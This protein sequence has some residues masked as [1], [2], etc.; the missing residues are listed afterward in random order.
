MSANASPWVAR[1]NASVST[2]VVCNI[3]RLG[4]TPERAFS[5]YSGRAQLE[6][7]LGAAPPPFILPAATE[8]RAR[9]PSLGP[10]AFCAVRSS[11]SSMKSA[12][13]NR[14]LCRGMSK[15]WR[16]SPISTLSCALSEERAEC[17]PKNP[18]SQQCESDSAL[19]SR[20]SEV[21]IGK[22]CHIF[23]IEGERG[24]AEPTRYG[25]RAFDEGN[26]PFRGRFSPHD[27]RLGTSSPSASGA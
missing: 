25:E 19:A 23:A 11:G 7:F 2:S 18:R 1:A 12:S 27:F 22:S 21:E 13:S 24:I 3:A 26:L 15:M 5:Y 16:D 20:Q 6:T 8:T 10:A 17:S 9:R 4:D 14:S